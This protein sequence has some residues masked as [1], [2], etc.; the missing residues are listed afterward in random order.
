MVYRRCPPPSGGVTTADSGSSPRPHTVLRPKITTQD[1]QT[2]G[3]E[4][5]AWRSG[6]PAVRVQV[7][8]WSN[9]GNRGGRA[10]LMEPSVCGVCTDVEVGAVSGPLT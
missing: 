3:P 8:Y 10:R 1:P 6:L 2:L 4:T 7:S 9:K 5:G